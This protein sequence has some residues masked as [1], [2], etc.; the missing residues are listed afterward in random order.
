[1]EHLK[2]ALSKTTFNIELLV[3]LGYKILWSSRKSWP[4]ISSSVLG[5]KIS[6]SYLRAK[7]GLS[8]KNLV[9]IFKIIG[10]KITKIINVIKISR[11]VY[12]YLPKGPFKIMKNNHYSFLKQKHLLTLPSPISC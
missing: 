8:S 4:L 7:L 6:N 12:Y 2:N 5:I 9:N 3:S 1:M 11:T 10:L